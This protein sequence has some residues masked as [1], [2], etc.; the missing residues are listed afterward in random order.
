MDKNTKSTAGSNCG[1]ANF[2]GPNEGV[3]APIT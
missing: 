1:V 2:D 3:N